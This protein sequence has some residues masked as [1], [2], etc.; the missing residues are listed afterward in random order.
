MPL[1]KV[2]S[3][4]EDKFTHK[5]FRPGDLYEHNDAERVAFLV[6]EGYLEREDK[7]SD[8]P[9]HTGGSWYELSNGEKVQGKEEAVA[10]EEELIKEGE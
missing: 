1:Y 8:F 4:F 5:V 3:S 6:G 9:K 10:A 7:K 2:K